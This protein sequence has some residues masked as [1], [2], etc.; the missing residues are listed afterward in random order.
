M[1]RFIGGVFADLQKEAMEKGEK[2]YF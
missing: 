1:R 2:K